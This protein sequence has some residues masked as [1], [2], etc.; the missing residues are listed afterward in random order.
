MSRHEDMPDAPYARSTRRT[1]GLLAVVGLIGLI[2]ALPDLAP[3]VEADP[4]GPVEAYHGRI[5]A[6]LPAP[7]VPDP[8]LPE[9]PVAQVLFLD[10]P[11]AGESVEAYLAAPGGSVAAATYKAGDEVVVTITQTPDRAEPFVA[12][13]DRW[14]V[15]ALAVLALVFG[16]AIVVVGGWHG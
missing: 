13:S 15:P 14:R 3:R 9:V 6:I 11:R 5:E 7:A 1:L 16:L 8:D 2:F 12:V 4:N 10:G